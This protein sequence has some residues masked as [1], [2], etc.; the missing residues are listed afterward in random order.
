ME[1]R[2][3]EALGGD[4]FRVELENGMTILATLCGRI[5]KYDLEPM[6]ERNIALGIQQLHEAWSDPRLL[7]GSAMTATVDF[8]DIF[9]TKGENKKALRE[10]NEV[11][12]LAEE[13]MKQ[14][15]INNH[16]QKPHTI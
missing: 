4:R 16:Q 15:K 2:V 7:Y 3:T 8:D 1:G 10:I 13:E 11:M 6:E 9:R 14:M 5:P 12:A